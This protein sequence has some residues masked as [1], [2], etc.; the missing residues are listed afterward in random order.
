VKY[1][2]ALDG[3]RAVAVIAVLVFHA[4]F[5]VA[6]GGFLGV[7]LFFTLSG[8]LITT[9]LLDEHE[10][11][12]TLSLRRFYGRRVRRLLP[13][14]YAC[15]LLVVLA[16]S[17]WTASQQ[18]RLP[19]DLIASVANVANWRF[20]FA[21]TSYQELFLGDPSPVAHFW[22]LAIEEQI[23]LVLPV[24]ALVALRRGRRVLA[25]TTGVLLAGSIAATL[26]TTDRDLVYNG[27][28]TRAAELLVGVALAQVLRRRPLGAG[29]RLSWLP[30]LAAVVGFLAVVTMTT[31]EQS[32]VYR[33]GLVGVSMISAV[34]IASVAGGR[35][36]SRLL[37]ARPLVAIGKVSYGIYLFH[38][39]VFMLL[40]EERTGLAR[41][42]LFVLQCFVT[43]ALTIVSYRLIEQPV[44]SGDVIGR[45]RVM[46]PTMLASAGVVALAA[47]LVVPTPSLTPTEELLAL[48][49]QDVVEFATAPAAD[50]GAADVES[51]GLGLGPPVIEVPEIEPTVP[52]VP[53]ADPARPQRIAVLG[54]APLP[55]ATLVS[56]ETATAVELVEDVRSD[57]S[58][59]SV[60]VP[61]CV[62][63]EDR[64]QALRSTGEIDALV[65]VTSSVE[66]DDALAKKGLVGSVAELVELGIQEEAMIDALLSTI[67]DATEAGIPV[68]W[69]T[70]AA[71]SSEFFRHFARVGVERPEVYRVAGGDAEL[72]DVVVSV[73]DDADGT[74]G[75]VPD[76]SD[77]DELRVLV[78]GDSTSLNFARALYDGSDGNLNVLWA[79][80]NGCPFAELEATRGGPDS[81]SA[82]TD[83]AAWHDKVVPLL[84]SFDPDVLFV[85]TG[86][87]ELVEHRFAG[88][89]TWRRAGDPAFA[90]ARDNE[91]DALLAVVPAD[92]PVL[93]ADL[94][95]ITIGGF[96]SVEM[97][98]P[99]RLAAINDQIVEWDERSAQLARFPYRDTLEAAERERPLDDQI[100]FDGTH[101]RVE[102]LAE[103]ARTIYVPELI[104]LVDQLGAALSASTVDG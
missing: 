77:G 39:P 91:L 99:E 22:S 43:G 26:L 10:S 7:S 24:V 20:A 13:A 49:E 81:Q 18:R 100:R 2:P 33:G 62:A 40:T 23:Y 58:L 45:D 50:D 59:S 42:P 48:G 1:V 98:S 89:P 38:W 64:W 86:P 3:L 61:G 102:P 84:D 25:T 15:L 4:Q 6:S 94:P 35:F 51:A 90:A 70:Q 76:G 63:L 74:A 46:V 66:V 101:P 21:P 29:G 52:Q 75:G 34:L 14:A 19:G 68:I 53:E 95:T 12:G 5:A 80:A 85:M 88:D 83:C 103:L 104:E 8:F 92:L 97:T 57:C 32:W 44:R 36:P 93:V 71:P 47:V 78:I 41:F 60:D 79:G 72:A 54:S 27:T 82:E 65:L 67:D 87:M 55:D 69:Y 17:W 16:S 11:T 31:L 73:V 96:S 37:E 56:I 30:G 9:L 28:H